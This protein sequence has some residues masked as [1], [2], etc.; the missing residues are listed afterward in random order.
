VAVSTLADPAPAIPTATLIVTATTSTEPVLPDS[1]RA[2]REDAFVAAVGAFTP[3]MA[4]LPGSLINRSRVYV[5]TLD[6]TRA[7]AGDLL[8]AGID[9]SVVVE[10]QDALNLPSLPSGPVIFKSV[11]HA[12]WDLAAA[13]LAFNDLYGDHKPRISHNLSAL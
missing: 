12:L 5:D 11:G 3:D 10:M 2:V 8:R 7:G 6:G 4:E 1:G 13:R 9:W